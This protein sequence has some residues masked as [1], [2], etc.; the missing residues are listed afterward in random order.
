MFILPPELR[1]VTAPD[2]TTSVGLLSAEVAAAL[3][4]HP[5]EIR[6]LQGHNTA[7]NTGFGLAHIESHRARKNY[8][9]GDLG[10]RTIVHMVHFAC[11]KPDRIVDG[12]KGR[13]LLCRQHGQTWIRVVIDWS[14]ERGFWHVIT[15]IPSA[16]CREEP[17]W[18][19]AD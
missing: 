12:N 3:G 14:A 18:E 16:T 17:R 6:L 15:A 5:G 2:G 4:V 1:S 7:R 11:S 8:A 9:L 13:F 19:R 10:F